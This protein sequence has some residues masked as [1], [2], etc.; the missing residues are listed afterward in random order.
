MFQQKLNAKLLLILNRI[1]KTICKYIHSRHTKYVPF[2]L[3][4]NKPPSKVQTKVCNGRYHNEKQS[5]KTPVKVC[6]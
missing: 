2:S 5:M 4:K 6:G 1:R 3:G